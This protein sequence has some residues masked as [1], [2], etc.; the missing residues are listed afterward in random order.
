[1]DLYATDSEVKQLE[2]R[3]ADM[4]AQ[5]QL[6]DMLALAWGLRQRDSR[7]ALGLCNQVSILL[8]KSSRSE[9]D[10]ALVYLRL[11]LIRAEERWLHADLDAAAGI[12]QAILRHPEVHL[13]A[14]CL[15]DAHRLLGF[16]YSDQGKHVECDIEMAISIDEASKVDDVLRRQCT[17][18]ALA[19]IAV[20]RDHKLAKSYFDRHFDVRNPPKDVHPA[21]GA[22]MNDFLGLYAGLNEEL[23]DSI[24]FL[25]KAYRLCLQSGQ[26]RRGILTAA[27]IGYTY[28]KMSNYEAALEWQQKALKLAKPAGWS[29]NIGNCLMQIGDTLRKM[30]S[31][32]AAEQMLHESLEQLATLTN[33]RNYA[34]TISVLADIALDRR[35]YHLAQNLFSQLAMLP[36]AQEQADLQQLAIQGQ[37]K[38][39][40]KMK[41]PGRDAS[42]GAGTLFVKR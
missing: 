22:L 21:L 7:Q 40:A 20:L 18:A 12:V 15:S 25:D 28:S 39:H 37:A 30:G 3:L 27:N 24:V 35:D 4:V 9:A 8:N 6:D 26:I 33:S 16:I 10:K 14:I 13:D 23:D 1:M 34:L 17:A 11:Q 29:P 19:R 32:D 42:S 41:S 31:L 5:E 38:A 2:Q 36:G